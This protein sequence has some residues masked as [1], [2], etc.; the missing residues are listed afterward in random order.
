M[1][2]LYVLRSKRDYRLTIVLLPKFLIHYKG[3]FILIMLRCSAS[4]NLNNFPSFSSRHQTICSFK[5]NS[6]FIKRR[7]KKESAKGISVS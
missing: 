6:E 7:G 5:R 3:L 2:D 4:T 1:T